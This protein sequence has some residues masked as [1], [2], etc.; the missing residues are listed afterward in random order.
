MFL[1]IVSLFFIHRI[2]GQ[3]SLSQAKNILNHYY[4]RTHRRL[5]HKIEQTDLEPYFREA[6]KA[7]IECADD[8]PKYF[9]RKLNEFMKLSSS[10]FLCFLFILDFETCYNY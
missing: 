4:T 8:M 3:Y 5:H 9:A 7:V 1:N 6:L 10:E 2:F